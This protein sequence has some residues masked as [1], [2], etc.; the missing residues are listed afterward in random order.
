MIQR[1]KDN[2]IKSFLSYLFFRFSQKIGNRIQRNLNFKGDYQFVDRIQGADK[3]MIIVA[4]YKPDLWEMTIPRMIRAVKDAKIDVCI[5]QPKAN[6]NSPKLIEIAEMNSWSYLCTEENKLSLAQNIAID[7]H[8]DAKYIYKVDEDIF[9]PQGFVDS[10]MRY[11]SMSDDAGY[12][13]GLYVPLLNVNGHTYI[14]LL[15]KLD[16][17]DDYSEKIE[18]PK[19]S[20]T[21]VKAHYDPEASYYLWKNILPFDETAEKILNSPTDISVCPH[22]FSIGAFMI[23]REFWSVVGGFKQS[24]LEAVLGVEEDQICVDCSRHSKPIVVF[25][26]ILVGHFS[27]GPQT[28][29]MTEKINELKAID[30]DLVVGELNHK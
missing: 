15:E 10:F 20:C 3:V 18:S 2:N 16:L 29:F 11:Y 28:K 7:L 14:K 1:F 9:L 22:R 12:D 27:F 24:P 8:K 4:G 17:I 23:T 30:E 13:G 5:V 26:N 19:S 21:N 25:N 6:E